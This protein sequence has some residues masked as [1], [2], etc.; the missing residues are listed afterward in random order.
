MEKYCE[1]RQSFIDNMV[2]NFFNLTLKIIGIFFNFSCKKMSFANQLQINIVNEMCNR[3]KK[4]CEFRQ[5]YTQKIT[6]FFNVSMKKKSNFIKPL[7]EN[8]AK[9]QH[10]LSMKNTN[11]IYLSKNLLISSFSP[12][13]HLDLLVPL[14][15]PH[16]SV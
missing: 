2:A 14:L 1:F 6:N 15:K 8:A 13:F 5:L 4:I 3:Y 10:W 7:G 9:F 11:L 16:P 12:G